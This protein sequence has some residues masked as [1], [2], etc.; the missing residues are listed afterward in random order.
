MA[1]VDTQKLLDKTDGSIY[2]LVI[3]AARRAMELNEGARKL[4]DAAPTMKFSTL[5]IREIEKGK[6]TLK[7]NLPK[8]KK[9]N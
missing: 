8:K 9:E 2:K 7:I 3:L 5:A 6:I 1:Y 4:I